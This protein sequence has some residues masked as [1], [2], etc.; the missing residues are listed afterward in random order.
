MLPSCDLHVHAAPSS[1]PRWGSDLD[2]VEAATRAGVRQ[3]VIKSHHEPTAARAAIASEYAR[4]RELDCRVLGSVTLNPWIGR[5]QLE[6]ALELGA[7]IVWWP[8]RGSDGSDRGLGLPA[9]HDLAVQALATRPGTLA[10]TGH[11]GAGAAATLV[12]ECVGAGVPVVATHAL[13][14][15]VGVGLEAGRALAAAGAFAE[16]DAYALRRLR[17]SGADGAAQVAALASAG[18]TFVS[19]DGGQT[20]TGNPFEF[21]AGELDELVAAGLDPSLLDRLIAQTDN[22][23]RLLA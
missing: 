4:R 17:R 5:E 2:L 20:E 22:L 13:N 14:P 16:V 1:T 11:L 7:A 21:L 18:P 6:R 12:E 10:A 23:G 9:L 19:S 3:V 15:D 8:T